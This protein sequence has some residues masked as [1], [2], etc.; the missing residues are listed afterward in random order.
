MIRDKKCPLLA[1]SF[2]DKEIYQ[3]I[4]SAEAGWEY[5][6]FMARTMKQ[7]QKW[8]GETGDNEYLF[9]LTWR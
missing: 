1:K 2:S 3:T 6:N 8:T 4:T 5:L 7:G 9:V